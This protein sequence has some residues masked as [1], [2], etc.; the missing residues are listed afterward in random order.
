MSALRYTYDATGLINRAYFF[1]VIPFL[2]T[3]LLSLVQVS[4]SVLVLLVIFGAI[5]VL[6]VLFQLYLWAT[7]FFI[8]QQVASGDWGDFGYQFSELVTDFDV[9]L[10]LLVIRIFWYALPVGL[11]VTILLAI[12]LTAD[13][14]FTDIENLPVSTI[15]LIIM[16][17]FLV[18]LVLETVFV[19]L[20]S[21][22][23]S[24]TGD[25]LSSFSVLRVIELLARAPLDY[26]TLL[27]LSVIPTVLLA[28]ASVP[29]LVLAQVPL[30]GSIL[31]GFL[32]GLHTM[33]YVIFLPNLQ[34]QIWARFK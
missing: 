9:K 16:A 18:Q 12:S 34:G 20:S 7:A 28:L 25:L 23:Y 2:T 31:L 5:A 21:F 11:L 30:L 17:F 10:R 3:L 32:A 24:E 15:G 13:V 33:Y 29:V 1:V 26:L 4:D 8:S 6:Q 19:N 14:K 27:G 22:I